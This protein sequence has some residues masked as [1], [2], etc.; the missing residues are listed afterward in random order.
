MDL[1]SSDFVQPYFF[2]PDVK[3]RDMLLTLGKMLHPQT[4]AVYLISLLFL[5]ALLVHASQLRTPALLAWTWLAVW[6]FAIAAVTLLISYFGDTAGARRHIMPSIE[7]FRLFF[8]VFMM[9][10]LDLSLKQFKQIE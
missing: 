9:P 10:F 5:L 4:S 3:H 8:W 6:F 2:T 1:L 7:M